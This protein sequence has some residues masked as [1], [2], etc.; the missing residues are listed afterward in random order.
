[1]KKPK[2]SRKKINTIKTK[3]KNP[4][5]GLVLLLKSIWLAFLVLVGILE[6]MIEII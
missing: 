6:I 2:E 4:K 5:I 3:D 1:M